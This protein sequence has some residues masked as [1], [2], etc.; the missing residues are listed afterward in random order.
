MPII[1]VEMLS[2]RTREQKRELVKELTVAFNRTC[3][4]RPEDVTIVIADVEKENWA[5]AG[6][7]VADKQAG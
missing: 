6:K 5:T 2:G 7:L 3:G 1:R 4:A